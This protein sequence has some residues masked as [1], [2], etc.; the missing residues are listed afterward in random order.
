MFGVSVYRRGLAVTICKVLCYR[1][2]FYTHSQRN[3]PE[4]ARFTE[5]DCALPQSLLAVAYFDKGIEDV[6]RNAEESSPAESNLSVNSATTE[7]KRGAL[8][9]SRGF[10]TYSDC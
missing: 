3:C 5:K 6:K 4:R 8:Y 10:S 1:C 7:N 9:C 2:L